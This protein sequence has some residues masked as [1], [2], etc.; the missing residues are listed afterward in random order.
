MPR[1]ARASRLASRSLARA[2]TVSFARRPIVLLVS[3]IVN[4]FTG[5]GARAPEA[6][7]EGDVVR[8]TPRAPAAPRRRLALRPASGGSLVAASPPESSTRATRASLRPSG[9]DHEIVRACR[10]P[11]R[12]SSGSRVPLEII[13]ATPPPS[14]PPPRVWVERR[15]C[16]PGGVRSSARRR[17]R[18]RSRRHAEEHVARLV[19]PVRAPPPDASRP[20]LLVHVHPRGARRAASTGTVRRGF[21]RLARGEESVEPGRGGVGVDPG[22]GAG[23]L[24]GSSPATC[25][26]ATAEGAR[27]LRPVSAS[28]AFLGVGIA[29]SRA[30]SSPARVAASIIRRVRSR[31]SA[32]GLRAVGARRGGVALRGGG[33][34]LRARGSWFALA[35][36]ALHR[37]AHRFLH[38]IFLEGLPALLDERARLLHPLFDAALDAARAAGSRNRPARCS[39][40][41]PTTAGPPVRL[42]LTSVSMRFWSCH[43]RAADRFLVLRRGGPGSRRRSPPSATPSRGAPPRL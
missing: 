16:P 22:G 19:S 35:R 32:A 20:V 11:P 31:S 27:D 13:A 26:G 8:G 9:G 21:G 36:R 23:A 38:V 10:D 5:G 39:G 37:L 24:R 17:R 14:P 29:A 41:S 15:A 7:F 28:K 2:S 42:W 1:A 12:S 4:Q 25:G 6:R 43:Q 18:R 40:R 34:R 33:A 30:L 3:R